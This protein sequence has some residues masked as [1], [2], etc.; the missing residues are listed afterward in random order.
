[1]KMKKLDIAAATVLLQPLPQWAMDASGSAI[2]REYV[3]ADF[4]QAFG[5]MTQVAL[6][7]ERANHHPEWRNVYNRVHITWTTHDA[8]GLT[9]NDMAMAK[10]CDEASAGYV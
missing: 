1:M 2:S 5:F 6:A 7:A 3:F 9:A 4:V 10:F 8:G